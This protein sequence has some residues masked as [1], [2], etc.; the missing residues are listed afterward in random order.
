[1]RPVIDL[2]RTDGLYPRAKDMC[3]SVAMNKEGPQRP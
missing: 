3:V 2:I 1:M